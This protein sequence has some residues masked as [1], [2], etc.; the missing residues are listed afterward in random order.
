MTERPEQLERLDT[1]L[2]AA[3]FAHETIF[4]LRRALLVRGVEDHE[5]PELLAESA[6]I[7]TVEVPR[8][9]GSLQRLSSRWREEVLLAADAA[10]RT[11]EEIGAG[12]V[13]VEPQLRALLERQGAIAGR[14][15]ALLGG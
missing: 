9:L 2:G 15:D 8:L 10:A 11:A 4:E 7:A 1:I 12:L 14:L 6:R 13:A 3:S 5:A